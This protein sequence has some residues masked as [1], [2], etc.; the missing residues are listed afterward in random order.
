MQTKLV[1]LLAASSFCVCGAIAQ[2]SGSMSNQPQP[3]M[4]MSQATK[5][6]QQTQPGTITSK[7]LENEGGK[8]I[9][10]YDIKTASGA[11]HEVNIDANTGAV[12]ANQVESKADEMNEAQ[13]DKMAA[14]KKMHEHKSDMQESSENTTPKR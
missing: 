5:I 9:Y 3:K 13:Q 12:I 6:A 11:T 10:S 7:E 8:Q 2:T 1:A 14:K 4:T